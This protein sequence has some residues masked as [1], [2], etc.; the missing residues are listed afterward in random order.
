MAWDAHIKGQD[1]GSGYFSG[2]AIDFDLVGLGLHLY[3]QLL[4]DA[5]SIEPERHVG[6]AHLPMWNLDAAMK[7][8]QWAAA[9][10]L[11]G[12][13]LPVWQTGSGTVAYTYDSPQWD[14]LWSACEDLGMTLFNHGGAGADPMADSNRLWG[15]LAHPEGMYAARKMVG[16]LIMGGVFER[17][18]KLRLVLT[19]QNAE[20][21]DHVAVELDELYM[22]WNQA[23]PKAKPFTPRFPG[24]PRLPSEY[25]RQSI[26]TGASFMAPYEA[27]DAIDSGWDDHM[28]WG[29]DYPHMEG[30]WQ[31]PRSEEEVPMTHLSLRNTFAGLSEEQ[32]RAMTGEVG[33]KVF[34]LDRAALAKVARRINSPTVEALSVPLAVED[35]P[36]EASPF[37][38]RQSWYRPKLTY[39]ARA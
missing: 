34:G 10:G 32:I 5:C 31:P 24:V 22:C 11:R 2:G 29:S 4:A 33:I 7:E 19:E 1:S 23:S 21:Y 8:L 18:A 6:L 28:I 16:R 36:E 25:I 3:N 30:T 14:P 35:I 38:F 26:F 39:T 37:A 9:A 20:W 13:N 12:V 17:H 27:R 15:V